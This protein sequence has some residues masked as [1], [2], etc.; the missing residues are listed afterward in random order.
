[1]HSADYCDLEDLP[2]TT[3]DGIW[4]DD[5]LVGGRRTLRATTRTLGLAGLA[6]GLRLLQSAR[7]ALLASFQKA[8]TTIWTIIAHLERGFADFAE[9]PYQ[10][11]STHREL[12]LLLDEFEAEH[13]TDQFLP[14][15][16]L[17][18]QTGDPER[19]VCASEI[20]FNQHTDVGPPNSVHVQTL[21]HV[22]YLSGEVSEDSMS[23]TAEE[24]AHKTP[25]VTRVVN[26]IAV[27]H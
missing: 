13:H 15:V 8:A 12:S 17:E 2:L 11:A 25:G 23:R 9:I 14:G 26:N 1:L 19:L 16:R 4:T 5:S 18:N 27:T 21:D 20:R 24:I 6:N 3:I 10:D 22:V 7:Y